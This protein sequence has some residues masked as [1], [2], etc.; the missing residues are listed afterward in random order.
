MISIK[1][2]A[3]DMDGTFLD[4]KGTYNPYRFRKLLDELKKRNIRFAIASGRS[5][6]ALDKLFADFRQDLVFVSENGSLVTENHHVHYEATMLPET[7]L[8]IIQQLATGAFGG[9]DKKL[10]LSGRRGSYVLDTVEKAYLDKIQHYYENVQLV[11]DFHRVDDEIFKVTAELDESRILEGADWLTQQLP[12]IK[13]M[14]TGFDSIDLIQDHVDKRTG[15]EGLCRDLGI[16]ADQVLAFG[17]NLNDFG[18]LTWAGKAIAT[19][20]ARDDIKAI[21]DQVIGPNSES[22]VLTYL[23]EF[24]HDN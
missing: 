8:R 18:M 19:A 20:N 6:L 3:S 13:A 9:S 15:L 17:D 22:S 2:I 10:L 16:G 11:A 1:L 4:D 14:T 23:E 12:N 5:H 7:Y 21:A 24:L